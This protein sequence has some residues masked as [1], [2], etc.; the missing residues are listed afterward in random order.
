MPK[1]TQEHPESASAIREG[2]PT[3]VLSPAT[4]LPARTRVSVE[5]REGEELA[6]LRA[7]V[8]RYVALVVEADAV[9]KACELEGGET[10][11]P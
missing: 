5:A 2:C 11:G 6:D 3:L 1:R 9:A 8:R 7:W 10:A 4:T